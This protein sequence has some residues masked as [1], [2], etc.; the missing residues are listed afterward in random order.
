[1]NYKQQW[2]GYL[3]TKFGLELVQDEFPIRMN[4]DDVIQAF[5]GRYGVK[6]LNVTL[7]TRT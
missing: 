1:M 3:D 5:Q 2:Q 6:I 7:S 4:R